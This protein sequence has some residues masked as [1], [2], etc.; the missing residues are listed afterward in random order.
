MCLTFCGSP[1]YVDD[2]GGNVC[3]DYW[4]QKGHCSYTAKKFFL[5]IKS[6][7]LEWL[8]TLFSLFIW[9]GWSMVPEEK[10]TKYRLTIKD[11]QTQDSGT[12]TCASPR[13]LTNSINIVVASKL[14]AIL[15]L[16]KRLTPN[17]HSILSVKL[18]KPPRT[19]ATVDVAF[20]RTQ[21]R[22]SCFVYMST[23]LYNR[24]NFKFNVSSLRFV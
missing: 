3:L 20:G 7:W 2:K 22:S 24:R 12:Y 10:A 18:P 6:N 9:S 17:T 16:K 13:G 21:I 14:T 19:A 4:I 15:M 11:I 8:R 1:W 23:R 5:Q